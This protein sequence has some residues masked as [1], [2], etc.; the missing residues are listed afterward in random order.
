M[1]ITVNKSQEI[2]Y[3]ID[4][5]IRLFE[6]WENEV[7]AFAMKNNAVKEHPELKNK[8]QRRRYTRDLEGLVALRLCLVLFNA[9]QNNIPPYT[10]YRLSQEMGAKTERQIDLRKKQLK[11]L[12]ERIA[13]FKMVDYTCHND[14]RNKSNYSIKASDEL[15]YFFY[16]YILA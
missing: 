8:Y 12:L 6:T 9:H 2:N 13:I 5:S 10:L 11:T 7:T 1:D 15:L 14:I 4:H 3:S 16:Q